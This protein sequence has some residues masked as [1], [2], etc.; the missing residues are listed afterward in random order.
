MDR[1][2]WTMLAFM[3]GLVAVIVAFTFWMSRE[4]CYAEWASSGRPVR[5]SVMG[6]CQVQQQG[7]TWIPAK[8]VREV[9]P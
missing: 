6:G 2:L 5:W 4:S 1:E 8:N 9:T 3:V 7:G